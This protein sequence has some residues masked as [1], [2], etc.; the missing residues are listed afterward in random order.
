MT[1]KKILRKVLSFFGIQRKPDLFDI[2][3]WYYYFLEKLHVTKARFL[4]TYGGATFLALSVIGMNVFSFV[5]C[6]SI[7][8]PEF[9]TSLIS[10]T[11]NF[12]YAVTT[13]EPSVQTAANDTPT[14]ST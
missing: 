3:G 4:L 2:Q 1:T 8:F 5:V 9:K 10:N 14:E 7:I 12:Q 6:L 13:Q 11:A